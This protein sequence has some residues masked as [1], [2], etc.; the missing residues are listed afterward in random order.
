M[1]KKKRKTVKVNTTLQHM[2]VWSMMRKATMGVELELG[3]EFRVTRICL[4]TTAAAESQLDDFQV[5]C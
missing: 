1:K 3:S 5:R 2:C 4:T